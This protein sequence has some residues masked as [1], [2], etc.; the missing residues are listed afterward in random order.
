MS[1]CYIGEIRMFG[2]NFAPMNWAFCDGRILSISE[3]SELFSLLGTTYGGDGITTFKLPDLRGRVPVH[4]GQGPNLTNRQTGSV[5]GTETVTLDTTQI[6]AHSHV[7]SAGGDGTVAD[8]TAHYP[9][10][11]IGF[12]LYSAATPD[13]TMNPSAVGPSATAG[14]QPHSNL[15]PTLCINYI[16]ALTG[17][18]PPRG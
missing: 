16:I 2:G 9:G 17:Y 3:Y 18:Y 14:A 8:P 12:N 7:V 13:S 5:F 1:D 10:N 15:M 4:S 11:S 6:P